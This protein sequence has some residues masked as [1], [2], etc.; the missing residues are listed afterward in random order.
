MAK[1]QGIFVLLQMLII[2]YTTR[3]LWEC[4]YKYI[5]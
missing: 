4:V 1:E 3:E 2:R 5:Y